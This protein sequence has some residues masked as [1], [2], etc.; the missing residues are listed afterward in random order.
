MVQLT[1]TPASNLVAVNDGIMYLKGGQIWQ[2]ANG[3]GEPH[4]VSK[5]PLGV[6]CFKVFDCC[7]EKWV[8]LVMNVFANMTPSQ[9]VVKDAEIKASGTS[10]TVFS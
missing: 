3:A 8:A 10:G 7:G 6:D 2:L 4:Q 1:R 9:T 5:L